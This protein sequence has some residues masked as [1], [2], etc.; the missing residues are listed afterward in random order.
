MAY[1]GSVGDVDAIGGLEMLLANVWQ[2]V[3][4]GDLLTMVTVDRGVI[5]RRVLGV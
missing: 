3:F 2:L 5:E 1:V 4:T